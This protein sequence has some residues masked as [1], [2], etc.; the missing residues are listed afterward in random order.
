MLSTRLDSALARFSA[1][2]QQG[3]DPGRDSTRQL[4]TPLGTVR[5]YDSGSSKPCVVL[6]PDGP[7]VI[8]TYDRLVGL[9]VER[10]RVVCFD[11]PGFGHSL[12]QP[13]YDHSL[14]QGAAVVIGVLDELGISAATLAFS[15]ANGFYA[16]RV[17]Q[18][19]PHRVSS[20][21][22]SQTPSL[23][24]MH[25]WMQRA[26]P[27]VLHMP[28]LGQAVAWATRSKTASGWYDAALPKGSDTSAFKRPALSVLARGGCFCLAGIVQGLGR[29]DVKSL[30]G[31]STP[32]TLVWG[33][34]DRSHKRTDPSTL[35]ELVPDAEIIHFEDCGHFPDI[36]SPGRFARILEERAVRVA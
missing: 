23:A 8:E 36:E 9:L 14:D 18:L 20:L 30:A 12:P 35:K 3:S 25:A 33:P 21:V 26:I 7:N 28:V 17:A 2:R 11:M 19:A 13:R 22:L 34:L 31:V 32:C 5:L 1:R 27:P 10:F 29:E 16:L 6:V 15:C 4:A 24:A